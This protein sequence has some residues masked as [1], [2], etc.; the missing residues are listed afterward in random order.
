M[1]ALEVGEFAHHLGFV[2]REFK[3]MAGDGDN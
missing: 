3:S 1:A 2:A